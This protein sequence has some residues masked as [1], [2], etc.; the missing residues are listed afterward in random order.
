MALIPEELVRFGHQAFMCSL[1]TNTNEVSQD[2]QKHFK[3]EV[4]DQDVIMY[5]E[6]IDQEK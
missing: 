6:S 1:I 3:E 2:I 5:V 4:E